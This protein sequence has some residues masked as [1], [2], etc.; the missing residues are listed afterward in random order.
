MKCNKCGKTISNNSSFCSSCANLVTLDGDISRM[1]LQDTYR[2]YDND[3]LHPNGKKIVIMFFALLTFIS[4]CVVLISK[5]RIHSIILFL[6]FT[7]ILLMNVRTVKKKKMIVFGEHCMNISWNT[8]RRTIEETVSVSEISKIVLGTY[9][10]GRY[11]NYT[12]E[13][14]TIKKKIEFNISDM[15]ITDYFEWF[16]KLH[17]IELDQDS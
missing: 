2:V 6:F 5:F 13:I 12:I 15:A 10:Q 1:K 16:C 9:P 17:G 14:Y 4:F 11:A 8:I 3:K 7:V